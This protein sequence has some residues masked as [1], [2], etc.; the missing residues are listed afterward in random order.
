MNVKRKSPSAF[1]V[2]NAKGISPCLTTS[3]GGGREPHIVQP[4]GIDKSCNKPRKIDIANCIIAREDSG[5]SNHKAEGTAVAIPVITPERANKRQNGRRFKENGEPFFT[6]TAQD[7]H[8]VAIDLKSF[9]SKT[10]GQAFRYGHAACLDHN[11]YQG[12]V[13]ASNI[14][15]IW[16]D[17]YQCY[18]TIRK[19]TPREC[20]RL[21]GWEDEYFEHAEQFNSNSQLYKQAGNGVTVTVIKHIA[22]RM[23]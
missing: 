1:R 19:L 16:S 17:K 5:V 23:E 11:C 12:I 21:Q 14:N 10:S 20:F 15:A 2:F 8:G 18:L 9:S 13:I 22:E 7:R 4:F 6:L 3:G